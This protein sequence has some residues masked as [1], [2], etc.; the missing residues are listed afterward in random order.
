MSPGGRG[1]ET[2]VAGQ[3]NGQDEDQLLLTAV[4]LLGVTTQ[5]AKRAA[6]ARKDEGF[7][8]RKH[9]RDGGGTRTGGV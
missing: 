9:Y 5:A 2:C 3:K 8:A 6:P 4:N 1:S 7:M